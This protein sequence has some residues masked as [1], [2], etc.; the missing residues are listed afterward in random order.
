VRDG[1]VIDAA[2]PEILH[3]VVNGRTSPSIEFGDPGE[4]RFRQ[5]EVA[6]LVRLDGENRGARPLICSPLAEPPGSLTRTSQIP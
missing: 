5:P 2:G 6:D 1:D 4:V 3:D